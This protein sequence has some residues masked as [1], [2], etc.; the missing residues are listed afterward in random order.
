MLP[1]AVLEVL[2]CLR[3][4][5]P[6]YREGFNHYRRFGASFGARRPKRIL[7]AEPDYQREVVELTSTEPKTGTRSVHMGAADGNAAGQ[8]DLVQPARLLVDSVAG[9]P[10]QS[11]MS[12][13]PRVTKPWKPL[14]AAPR[15]RWGCSWL[16]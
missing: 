16:A 5:E 4:L 12:M 8:P 3:V 13:G 11:R 10:M 1:E 14:Q 9:G 7:V 6:V 15:P 2:K